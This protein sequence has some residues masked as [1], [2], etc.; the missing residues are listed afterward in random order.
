MTIP[1]LRVK[2]GSPQCSFNTM[3]CVNII[4]YSSISN[5]IIKLSGGSST[6]P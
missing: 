4:K 1:E 3:T 2:V 6:I 5:K